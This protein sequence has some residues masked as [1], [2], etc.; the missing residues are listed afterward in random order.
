[1]EVVMGVRRSIQVLALCGLWLVFAGCGPVGTNNKGPN[2]GGNNNND[3]H[4]LNNNNDPGQPDGSVPDMVKIQGTVW[5]PGADKAETREHNR[6]PIPG[7]VVIAY[8]NPP[9][10]IPQERYCN[11]CVEIPEGTPHAFADPVTGAFELFLVPNRT[12]YLTVQKGEFRRVTQFTAPDLPNETYTFEWTDGQPRPP[13]TTLP[14]RT[15]LAAGDNIPKIA[16]IR[17][18]YEDMEPLFTVLGFD[19]DH[20]GDDFDIYC[21]SD[22]FNPCPGPPA[23][24]LLS[25][26]AVLDQYNLIIVTCGV[27]WPG[28]GQ[29]EEN[30]RQWVE[31]G[32][33]LYVDDFNYDFVEQPWPD[34]LA[35][36]IVEPY[37]EM[38]YTGEC[39]TP[40]HPSVHG[41]CNSWDQY[42]FQGDPGDATELGAWLNL[43]EVNRGDPLLLQGAW[44]YIMEMGEGE[45]FIDPEHG[46]G[47]NGEVYQLPKVWMWN[48][49][50]NPFSSG[51]L[52]ATVS[53]PYYCGKVLYTVYHT[54]S[55]GYGPDY[56]LLLQEKIMMY[57]IMEIQT[58]SVPVVVQ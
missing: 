58:C 35:W 44:D 11:E 25:D 53:W 2:G 47:P 52:P 54:H 24:D 12:Y 46:T 6:F 34:F 27:D 3:N 45:V 23:S 31:N 20:A 41:S 15:D 48:I 7:A 13:E 55:T 5:S 9:P 29:A 8:N 10:E 43:P 50:N 30:L 36:Y 18:G 49:S 26:P 32:G 40:G 4:I 17:G 38:G 16:M 39:G 21:Y 14:N 33:K 37:E 28:S 56:E 51:S 22:I 42:D 57:L 1:M 19:Y